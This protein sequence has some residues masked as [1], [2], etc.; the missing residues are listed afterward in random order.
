ML[1]LTLHLIIYSGSIQSILRNINNTLSP[2]LKESFL[3]KAT[4]FFSHYPGCLI[5]V[6]E[7]HELWA[8]GVK[9]RPYCFREE[10][11]YDGLMVKSQELWPSIVDAFPTLKTLFI[12]SFFNV[13]FNCL[14][15][16][17]HF[18]VTNK[19]SYCM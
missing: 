18:Y 3:I 17:L 9:L 2:S 10:E 15:K 19:Y 13:I 6:F 14:I 4:R 16:M 5:F 11:A 1:E 12:M 7:S 8:C